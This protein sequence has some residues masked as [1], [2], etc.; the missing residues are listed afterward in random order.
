M[1]IVSSVG[2]KILEDTIKYEQDNIGLMT[3]AE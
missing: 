3:E 2:E 1:Q